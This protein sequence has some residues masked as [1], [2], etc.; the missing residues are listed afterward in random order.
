MDAKRPHIERR[1]GVGRDRRLVQPAQGDE[2]LAADAAGL[3]G[4][5]LGDMPELLVRLARREQVARIKLAALSAYLALR[6]DH[7][8]RSDGI[9][10][11]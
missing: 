10:A 8:A 1:I 9:P 3:A 4:Q 7:G 6:L 11:H 5:A 2:S